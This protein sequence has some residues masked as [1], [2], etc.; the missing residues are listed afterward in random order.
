MSP[1]RLH[2]LAAV[3]VMVMVMMVLPFWGWRRLFVIIVAVAD[4]HVVRVVQLRPVRWHR[5]PIVGRFLQV[6]VVRCRKSGGRLK[7]TIK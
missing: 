1:G 7:Q 5:W 4:H 2:T 3:A 6:L